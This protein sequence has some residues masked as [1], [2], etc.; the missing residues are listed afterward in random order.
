MSAKRCRQCIEMMQ[1][2]FLR[3][4]SAIGCRQYFEMRGEKFKRMQKSVLRCR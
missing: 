2:M 4:K 1:I 3:G